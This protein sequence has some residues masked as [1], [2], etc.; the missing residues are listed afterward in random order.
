MGVFRGARRF[1]PFG[2]FDEARHDRVHANALDPPFHRQGAGDLI[3][4]RL[5]GADM[6]LTFIGQIGLRGRDVDDAGTGAFQIGVGPLHHVDRAHQVDIDHRL[7]RVD[8]HFGVS[9]GKLPAAPETSTSKSPKAS[10]NCLRPV[11]HGMRVA[12]VKGSADGTP[13]LPRSAAF[14]AATVSSTL[15]CDRLATASPCW[16]PR[17][18]RPRQCPG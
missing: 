10:W 7:E 4:A 15:S 12:H 6:G 11:G 17:P 14:S 8:R 3:D 13:H 18:Q 1:A 16:P 5:G 2:A 9:A